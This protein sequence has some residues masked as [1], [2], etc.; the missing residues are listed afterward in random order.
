MS[1]PTGDARGRCR[2]VHLTP[3]LDVGGLE[4]LLVEFA[5][6]ADRER[7]DLHFL[8]L[9]DRGPVADAIERYGWPVTA[10]H[11][12]AGL[13]PG[14]VGRLARQLRRLRPDVVH[15]HDD[16]P[17]IY[18]APAAWLAGVPVVVHTRHH[19]GSRLS[20]RQ[21]LLVRLA[22]LAND[23]FVCIAHDSARWARRQGI[24][25]RQL[26]VIHNGIDLTRFAF[27][28]PDPGGPAVLVARLSP[29]KD[30]A[31]LLDAVARV[32]RQ[33]TD[34]RLMIAGD[35]PCRGELERRAAALEV[36]D[37]VRFLGTVQAVPALLG[38]ARLFALSSLTEGISLTLLE[39]MARG[40]PVVATRVGGNP[41][42]VADGETGRLVPP[43]DPEALAQA[44]LDL[45][46]RPDLCARMGMAGRRRV[47]SEFDVR[48][49]VA[50]YEALYL[51]RREPR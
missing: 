51:G 19:Q 33:R 17:L 11:A 27:T 31:T 6:C 49:M 36:G 15:S 23:R 21:R 43:R 1:R 29:E 37:H 10:L 39:A 14:L 24:P 28:G 40:L 8:S 32:V 22:S 13:R 5:R 50:R 47:E 44:L 16:R 30:V 41:E 38:T 34:F 46:T 3:G 35:G 42:V 18:G 2:V 48:R 45:W 7:F 20:A 25:P 9:T 4:K 12:P 26:R